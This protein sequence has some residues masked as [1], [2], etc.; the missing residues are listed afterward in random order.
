MG[1]R[2]SQE[3]IAELYGGKASHYDL[4]HPQH[5]VRIT[6]P[7]Y[8]SIYEITQSQ[9]NALMDTN[10]SPA[11]KPDL[12]VEHVSWDDCKEF[13]KRLSNLNYAHAKKIVIPAEVPE[14]P[15]LAQQAFHE[16]DSGINPE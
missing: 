5:P 13:C 15:Q 4:E 3:K 14:S 9:W 2:Y 10:P 7:F 6:K 1:S 12:P 8:L 11:H 16:G